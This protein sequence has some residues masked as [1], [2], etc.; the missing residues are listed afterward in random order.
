[1]T[2]PTLGLV[3]AIC[4]FIRLTTDWVVLVK[5]VSLPVCSLS[6]VVPEEPQLRVCPQAPWVAT[7]F[8]RA[9]F[10]LFPHHI[11]LLNSTNL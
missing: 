11:Q 7:G 5:S 1:M 6:D 9:L 2:P 8:G 10:P 4:L 3:I